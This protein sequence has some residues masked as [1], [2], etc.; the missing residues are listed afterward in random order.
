MVGHPDLRP[1][2]W[3]HRRYDLHGIRTHSK[4][5]L[6]GGHRQVDLGLRRNKSHSDAGPLGE[7]QPEA[8]ATRFS[9]G[10]ATLRRSETFV[11]GFSS[12]SSWVMGGV[13][14]GI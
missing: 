1:E 5:A 6:G 14:T 11:F 4:W 13:I 12:I 10:G 3:A 9:D 8:V 7:E 2:G